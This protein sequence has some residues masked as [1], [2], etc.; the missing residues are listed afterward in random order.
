[1]GNEKRGSWAPCVAFLSLSLSLSPGV[2]PHAVAAVLQDAGNHRNHRALALGAGDVHR[3]PCLLRGVECLQEGAHRAEVEPG[4]GVGARGGRH[5]R[6]LVVGER[7][8]PFKRRCAEGSRGTVPGPCIVRFQDVGE[9]EAHQCAP[10]RASPGVHAAG[11]RL[12]RV[13]ECDQ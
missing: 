13:I 8:E 6:L 11:S 7:G 3:G 4:G 12:I 5:A 10:H 9:L 1:M 2:T